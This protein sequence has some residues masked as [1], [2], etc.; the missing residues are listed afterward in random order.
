LGEF[1]YK[2]LKDTLLF[3]D[4]EWKLL[5]NIRILSSEGREKIA[6]YISDLTA[7]GKYSDEGTTP[8]LT[9]KEEPAHIT[10]YAAHNDFA[11][12]EEEQR[13][14]RQDIEDLLREAAKDGDQDDI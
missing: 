3:D 14:M 10:P 8:A 6:N 9:L 11:D 4:T 7:T 5:E 1:R 13:L 12:D 2:D